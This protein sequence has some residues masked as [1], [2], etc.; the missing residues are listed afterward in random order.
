MLTEEGL[1]NSWQRHQ[2]NHI[3]LRDGLQNLGIDYFLVDESSR[4]P[5]LNS[6]LY[7]KKYQ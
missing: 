1:E 5:Q 4:L 6:I 2:D 7:S 3:L